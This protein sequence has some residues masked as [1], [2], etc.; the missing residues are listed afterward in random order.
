MKCMYDPFMST[1]GTVEGRSLHPVVPITPERAKQC[2]GMPAQ[3]ACTDEPLDAHCP[4]RIIH[5]GCHVSFGAPKTRVSGFQ[6]SE[7]VLDGLM[8]STRRPP[9]LMLL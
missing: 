6:I 8:R 5:S 4:L 3:C 2:R 7:L 9:L 1:P